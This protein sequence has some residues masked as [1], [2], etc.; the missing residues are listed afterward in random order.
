VFAAVANPLDRLVYKASRGRRLA[1]PRRFPSLLL[2][3]T[4][5]V[6]GLPR[7]C[8][9]LFVQPHQAPVVVGTSFGRADTPNWAL[10]LLATPRAEVEISGERWPVV[11]RPLA[12]EEQE[13]MWVHFDALWPAYRDYRRRIDG[14]R[15][16]HMFALEPA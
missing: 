11:A 2:H 10:N 6:S 5:R 12:A 15:P 14:R 9:L 13:S 8:P 3:T 1:I 4:G 7:S 16:I